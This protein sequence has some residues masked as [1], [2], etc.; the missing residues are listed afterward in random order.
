MKVGYRIINGSDGDVK[1]I[2]VKTPKTVIKSEPGVKDVKDVNVFQPFKGRMCAH[3]IRLNKGN[4]LDNPDI[5]DTKVILP[6][7]YPDLD[8]WRRINIPAWQRILKESQAAGDKSREDYARWML[9][10]VLEV[11]D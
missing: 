8:E 5:P 9:E 6:T 2:E 10:K 11:Q 1:V 4:N 3:N 7:P